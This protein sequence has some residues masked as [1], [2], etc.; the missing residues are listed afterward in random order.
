[1]YSDSNIV[2]TQDR[3]NAF[4]DDINEDGEMLTGVVER[5]Y[6]LSSMPTLSNFNPKAK[7]ITIKLWPHESELIGINN[8]FDGNM[9]TVKL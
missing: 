7:S 8:A 1:M 3:D 2:S 9:L 5:E 4:V 6:D